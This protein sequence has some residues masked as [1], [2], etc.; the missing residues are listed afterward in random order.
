LSYKKSRL[1][2]GKIPSVEVQ[3]DFANFLY[4]MYA[5]AKEDKEQVLLFLDPM[6]QIH[7]NENDYS[8][9]FK[10]K[11][12]T[13]QIKA[14]TGRRRINIV[15]AINPVSLAPTIIITEENCCEELIHAFLYEIRDQ[16]KEAKTICVVLDNAR[17]QRAYSVND[18]AREINIDLVF[19]PPYCPNLNL[20]ERLWKFFKKKVI[21]NKY[22][23]TF[24]EFE[25]IV[26]SFFEKFDT[27]QN[28]LRILLNFKFG[29]IKTS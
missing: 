20:I 4:D 17:Y 14:N 1:I 28:E 2:P 16:Y 22:Y 6:H 27:N 5:V 18:L 8:W 15:G 26:V 25:E 3:E 7:N 24:K 19:L 12:Y 21:K 29:I 23:S 13:K 9:Q 11:Q 10:G